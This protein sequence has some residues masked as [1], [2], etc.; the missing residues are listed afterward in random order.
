[1]TKFLVCSY[2]IFICILLFDSVR[3]AQNEFFQTKDAV[4]TITLTF[5][6]ILGCFKDDLI[7]DLVGDFDEASKNEAKAEEKA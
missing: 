6:E 4:L 5:V 2:L 7:S 3:R 1:M